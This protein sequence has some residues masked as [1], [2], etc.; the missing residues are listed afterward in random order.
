VEPDATFRFGENRSI[1]LGYRNQI[2]RN[3]EEDIADLDKNAGNAL[4]TFRFNIHNG[5][6]VFYEH[7]NREYHTTIPPQPDRDHYGHYGRGRYTYF[8]NP[9]T[10][11][12]VEYRYLHRDFD[13]ESTFFFDYDVHDPRIGFSHELYENISLTA[14]A[15]YAYRDAKERRR[16][17]DTFSGRGDLSVEYQRLTLS[18]Y[19][20][21]GFD[22]DLTSAESLGFNEFWR[23]GIAGRYQLLERLWAGAFFYIQREKFLDLDRRDRLWSARGNLEYQLLRWLF[24]AFEYE[25]NERDSNIPLESY[26]DNR[27]FGRI[28]AQYDITEHF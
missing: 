16:D 24:L 14:S 19:G 7:I 22:E 1:R 28:T 25:H 27:Y 6:E 15:G 17:E 11:A 9:R 10:S 26:E 20:E 4:L 23:A 18:L 12:F 2:L 21:T 8:F 13:R 3:E 5:I